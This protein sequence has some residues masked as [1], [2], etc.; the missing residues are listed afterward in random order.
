MR[1]RLARIL[2]CLFLAHPQLHYY[3]GLH[4]IALVLLLVFADERVAFAALERLALHQ[5][6]DAL[7]ES[8]TEICATLD[9]LV[10]LVRAEDPE[11]GEHLTDAHR[12]AADAGGRMRPIFALPWVLTWFAH[13]I[14]SRE[15]Q[16]VVMDYLLSSHPLAPVY[17]SAG[18]LCTVRESLLELPADFTSMHGFLMRLPSSLDVDGAIERANLFL[19]HT[20]PRQLLRHAGAHLAYHSTLLDWPITDYEDIYTLVRGPDATA[21]TVPPTPLLWAAAHHRLALPVAAAS[22][23]VAVAL[24]VRHTTG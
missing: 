11:L 3:Q 24:I 18:I 12:D 6:R 22:V 15:Q 21:A 17:L 7:H 19:E 10:P 13:S 4:D 8:L 14:E 5:L 16:L 9:L 23:A 1:R 2:R 20:S